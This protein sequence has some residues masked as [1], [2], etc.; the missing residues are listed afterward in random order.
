MIVN[1]DVQEGG[2]AVGRVGPGEAWRRLAE[3][4]TARLVDVRTREEWSFV[5]APDLS[6]L[7]RPVWL[8]EWRSFPQM[9]VNASFEE[10]FQQ[11]VAVDNPQTVF[12]ICRSGARSMEAAQAAARILDD[13]QLSL[14]NVDEGFEGDLDENGQ[15]GRVNGWKACGLPWRQS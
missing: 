4:P 3:D 11:K 2:L 6:A 5:G 8:I 14:F 9:V 10:E 12:F 15:R 7:D 1:R 13:P